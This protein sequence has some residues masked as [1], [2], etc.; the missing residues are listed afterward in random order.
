MFLGHKLQKEIFQLNPYL[1]FFVSFFYLGE[2]KNFLLN[3]NHQ[4]LKT[5]KPLL[6]AGIVQPFSR[7]HFQRAMKIIHSKRAVCDPFDA[8][9]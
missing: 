7:N 2:K 6:N 5:V 8:H 4:W 9:F 1:I 3:M